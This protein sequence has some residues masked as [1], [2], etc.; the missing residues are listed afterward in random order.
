MVLFVNYIYIIINY[1]VAF[2][3]CSR[4]H[5]DWYPGDCDKCEISSELSS[6]WPVAWSALLSGD[7]GSHH[8]KALFGSSTYSGWWYTYPPETYQSQL[9][10][11]IIP[12]ILEKIKCFKPPTNISCMFS[13]AHCNLWPH[14]VRPFTVRSS[15]FLA[16]AQPEDALPLTQPGEKKD[17]VPSRWFGFYIQGYSRHLLHGTGISS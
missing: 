3:Q 16:L 9:G 15:T 1:S 4:R 8:R 6:P 13:S 5:Q 14:A 11:L 10:W 12:N 17:N 7:I 2:L